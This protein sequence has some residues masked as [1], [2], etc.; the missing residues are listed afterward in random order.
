MLDTTETALLTIRAWC[1]EGSLHPLRAE[2]R[3]A[4][5]VARGFRSTLTFV[6]ADAVVEAVREFLDRVSC[7]SLAE[8]PTPTPVTPMSRP[9]DG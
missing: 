6:H 9:G 5:D 3:L 2:I 8:P 4:D 1:E 7:A